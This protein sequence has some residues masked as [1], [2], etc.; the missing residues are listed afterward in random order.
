MPPDA[1]SAAEAHT[2]LKGSVERPCEQ[3]EPS[4]PVRR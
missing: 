3:S 4:D 1:E 2:N